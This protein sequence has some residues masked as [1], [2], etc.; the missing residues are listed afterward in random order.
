[1]RLDGLAWVIGEEQRRWTG[2]REKR[3]DRK[4][5]EGDGQK[6]ERLEIPVAFGWR[7]IHLTRTGRK[8]SSGI[9]NFKSTCI[10]PYLRLLQA[11]LHGLIL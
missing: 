6:R 9:H 11:R 5:G 3:M 7:A 4:R 2:K 8:T 1:M 10:F